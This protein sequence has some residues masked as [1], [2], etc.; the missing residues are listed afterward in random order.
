MPLLRRL[1]LQV[2][3]P[4]ENPVGKGKCTLE[5]VV[6]SLEI[7]LYLNYMH[8]FVFANYR[9]GRYDLLVNYCMP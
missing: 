9:M 7:I 6:P 3:V 8:C 4:S 2:K 1:L 5:H